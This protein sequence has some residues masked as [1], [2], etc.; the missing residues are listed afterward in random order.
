MLMGTPFW[1]KLTKK[2]SSE[3]RIG[4]FYVLPLWRDMLIVWCY[5]T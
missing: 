3:S 5:E 4:L 2:I 1:H